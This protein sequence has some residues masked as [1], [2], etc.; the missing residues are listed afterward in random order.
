MAQGEGCGPGINAASTL[1]RTQSASAVSR[2]LTAVK[3]SYETLCGRMTPLLGEE[4]D[5]ISSRL[6]CERACF[7]S[8]PY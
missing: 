1:N 8:P 4:A 3:L 6:A 2:E 7:T 5:Y